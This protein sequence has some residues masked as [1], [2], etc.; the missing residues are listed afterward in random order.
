MVDKLTVPS[1]QAPRHTLADT[2]KAND[3]YRLIREFIGTGNP[4]GPDVSSPLPVFDGLELQVHF[5][6][7]TDHQ[8]NGMFG[9]C[10]RITATV[11]GYLYAQLLQGRDIDRIRPGA[12]CLDEFEVATA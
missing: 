2:A 3:A 5:S 12:G 7:H 4:R 6:V 11:V 1:L 10:Y 8:G 9:N